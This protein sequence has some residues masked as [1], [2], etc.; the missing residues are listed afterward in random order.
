MKDCHVFSALAC[1]TTY[2]LYP[3]TCTHALT[4][5]EAVAEVK[6]LVKQGGD[7]TAL[8]AERFLFSRLQTDDSQI[9]LLTLGP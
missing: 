4:Q 5:Q 3:T 8:E 6:R 7:K 2:L 9:R 1:S